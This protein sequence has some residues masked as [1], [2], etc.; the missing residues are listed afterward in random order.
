VFQ[1][2]NRNS[3]EDCGVVVEDREGC[4]LFVEIQTNAY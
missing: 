1:L 3:V 2:V 4:V